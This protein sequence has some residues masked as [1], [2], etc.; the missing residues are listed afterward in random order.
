MIGGAFL[1]TN[2]IAYLLSADARKAEI[3]ERRRAARS[4]CRC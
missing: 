1:D 2:V 4:A 3:A